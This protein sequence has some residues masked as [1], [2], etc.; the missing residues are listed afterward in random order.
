MPDFSAQLCFLLHSRE[1][2]M[3]PG[4]AWTA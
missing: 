4:R 2:R 1:F 3:M